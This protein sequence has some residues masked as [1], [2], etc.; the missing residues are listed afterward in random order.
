M[1][2]NSFILRRREYQSA[3]KWGCATAAAHAEGAGPLPPLSL[4][5]LPPIMVIGCC[6]AVSDAK[7]RLP[8]PRTNPGLRAIKGKGRRDKTDDHGQ[9]FKAHM[10]LSCFMDD[11]ST[12]LDASSRHHP[13]LS[14][15]CQRIRKC[16][17]HRRT[18]TWARRS[19]RGLLPT[20]LA[21]F[22]GLLQLPTPRGMDLHLTP[23]E[24][25]VRRH[26]TDGTVEAYG[27]VTTSNQGRFRPGYRPPPKIQ[28]INSLC[29]YECRRT[30]PEALPVLVLRY[31]RKRGFC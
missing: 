24:H 14:A 21:L 16:P 15:D 5:N 12:S 4:A 8:D 29:S 23:G 2:C 3:G 28:I 27:V 1:C 6:A 30:V 13:T 10:S 7:E 19:S 17:L 18:R 20:N 31:G 22:S 26:I 25:I 11:S 9:R